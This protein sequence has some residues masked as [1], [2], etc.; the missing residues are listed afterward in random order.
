MACGVEIMGLASAIG[1]IGGALLG[2]SASRRASD[3]QSES[4][5]KGI[6]ETRLAREE[7]F[8]ALS[9][10]RRAGEEVLD[11]LLDFV[12]TGP[13]S[14]FERTQGFEAIQKSAAAGG[15]LESGGT[16]K[17]LTE[18]NAGINQ[19]FRTQRFN[20]LLS[21]ANLG[22]VSA[23]GAANV[24]VSSGRD[25][26]NLLTGQGNVEAAGIVGSTNALTTG[27]NELGS[28]LGTLRQ[29]VAATP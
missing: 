1:S 6:E 12:K 22:Q 5:D 15:K 29:P 11:P 7:A 17:A 3:K 2:S 13:E 19:K 27:I 16:L 23:A 28:F 24:G 20:E 25:I 14:E 10:F 18:F 26:T 4:V 8:G 9:P 21:L